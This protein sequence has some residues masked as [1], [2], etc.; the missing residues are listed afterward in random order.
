M[1]INIERK[2]GYEVNGEK[3][4]DVNACME[5]EDQPARSSAVTHATIKPALK[6]G[7]DDKM[8]LESGELQR[9]ATSASSYH[10]DEMT[11]LQVKKSVGECKQDDMRGNARVTGRHSE[12][13]APSQEACENTDR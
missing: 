4:R 2:S 9:S 12:C 1:N 3:H 10:C 11:Q 6:Y 7:H 13:H 5:E 8:V